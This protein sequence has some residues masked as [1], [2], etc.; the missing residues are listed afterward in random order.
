MATKKNE[1]KKSLKFIDVLNDF[2]EGKEIEFSNV[3]KERDIQ[4]IMSII[5]DILLGVSFLNSKKKELLN[6]EINKQMAIFFYGLLQC[7]SLKIEK[8]DICLENYDIR[9]EHEILRSSIS[10]QKI[11]E[12]TNNVFREKQLEVISL[13]TE[14]F[15]NIPGEESL[16]KLEEKMTRM[17]NNRSSED[18]KMINNILDYNDPTL[19]AIK[20]I[21]FSSAE[22][23][24]NEEMK[25]NG[26]NNTKG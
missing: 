12:I 26:N 8:E 5:D 25:K 20:E 1:E 2:R 11:I 9:F 22:N 3:V 23:I 24:S 16:D 13:L 18:L 15:K 10:A 14:E 4:E 6:K 7:T 17:F 19:K 21:I